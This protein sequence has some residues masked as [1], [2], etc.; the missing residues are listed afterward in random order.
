[1]GRGGSWE[2]TAGDK[3]TPEAGNRVGKETGITQGWAVG[4]SGNGGGTVGQAG[5]GAW[6]W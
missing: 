5:M 3:G 4:N 6:G 1:M 2:A